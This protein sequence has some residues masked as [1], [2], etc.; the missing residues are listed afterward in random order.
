[1]FQETNRLATSR[2][3]LLCG[4]LLTLTSGLASN[5]L[6]DEVPGKIG[7]VAKNLIAT[8]NGTF[9]RWK[10]V[11]ASVDPANL[12]AGSVTIEIDVASVD[13]DSKRRDDH[14]RNEDFFET[15]RWPTATV[16][17][18]S[19]KAVDGDHDLGKYEAQFDIEIRDQRKT[20][21]GSFEVTNRSPLE[22]RGTVTIDRM[23]FGVGTPK[24]WN[25]MSITEEI[26]IT[27]EARLD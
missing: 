22:V 16:R 11:D 5:A 23:D 21:T 10:F 6:A 24:T 26:P 25:P 2:A 3:V 4:L 13:T 7:F 17:V 20:L 12:A 1:M 9:H 18:H 27:F 8:A 15:S 14:L 19:A